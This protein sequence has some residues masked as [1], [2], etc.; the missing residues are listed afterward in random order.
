[1]LI[2][3]IV[4]FC[5][6][7]YRTADTMHICNNC[8]HPSECSGNCKK[9][10][11]QVHYPSSYPNGK[12]DYNCRNMINYYVCNYTSKYASEMVYLLRKSEKLSI[13][14]DYRV[15]SIGCGAAPDLVAFEKYIY[16]TGSNKSVKYIGFDKNKLWTSVHQKIKEYKR[17]IIQNSQ[18]I[19]TD[20]V[21]YFQSHKI[22]NVNIVVLQYVISHF[23]NTNQ[24]QFI[25][26]FLINLV[27]KVVANKKAGE[28]LIILINDANSCYT[29]RDYFLDT[30]KIL[31][32]KNYNR[33][34]GQFYFDY[35]IQND[36]QRYGEKHESNEAFSIEGID[37]TAYDPWKVCSSAQLIIEID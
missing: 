20:V 7:E 35:N 34:F 24:I 21:E 15:L 2:H 26:D 30:V 12:K 18:F 13:L 10:L 8:N 11:E 25:Q 36:A 22:D 31:E 37:L 1:M 28:P 19:Y 23:Y 14:Q 33:T 9:C 27:E 6:S 16:E 5:D 29:G 17:D 3:E 4:R 32:N